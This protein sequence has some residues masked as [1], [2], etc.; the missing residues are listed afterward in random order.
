MEKTMVAEVISGLGSVSGLKIF[1]EN[2]PS[3]SVHKMLKSKI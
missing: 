2:G 1:V 3:A